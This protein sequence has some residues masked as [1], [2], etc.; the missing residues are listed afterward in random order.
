MQHAKSYSLIDT[1]YTAEDRREAAVLAEMERIAT[2]PMRL[3][4][5]VADVDEDGTTTVHNLVVLHQA[6]YLLGELAKGYTIDEVAA[7]PTR[8]DVLLAF[9]ALLPAAEDADRI[10][11]R[12]VREAAE[13]ELARRSAA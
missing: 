3:A 1:P 8:R 6:V 9:R 5:A 11:Q 2:D 13:D 10:V 7:R 4:E 12:C